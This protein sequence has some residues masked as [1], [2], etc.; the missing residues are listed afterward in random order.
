MVGA[1]LS[2]YKGTIMVVSHDRYFLNQL[3]NRIF[4]VENHHL[5]CYDGNYDKF[6]EEKRVR[7]ESELRAYQT[8]KKRFAGRKI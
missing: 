2:G 1:V 8:S 4:E 7:R 3:V 5:R 6:A